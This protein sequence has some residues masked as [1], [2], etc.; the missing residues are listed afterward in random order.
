MRIPAAV[1]RR[2]IVLLAAFVVCG[3]VL[4]SVFLR[5]P[6]AIGMGRYEAVAQ[7]KEGAGLYQGAEVTYRGVPVGKVRSLALQNGH[8]TA[9]MSLRED[10]AIPSDV[11]AAIR[12]RSAVGEQYIALMEPET[13]TAA[14]RLTAGGVVPLSRTSQ[15]VEIGPLLDN[16]YALAKSLNA[17]DVNSTVTELGKA[18]DGRA[19]DLQ[20]IIDRGTSFT[21]QVS[22]NLKPTTRLLDDAE[23][24]LTRVNDEQEHIEGLTRSLRKVTEELRKGDS[25]LRQLMD[26]GPGFSEEV[27]RLLDDLDRRL[28]SVVT[29]LNIVLKVLVAYDSHLDGTL[30]VYPRSQATVQSV[31]LGGGDPN[32]IRLTLSNIND[33]AE[34]MK[35]FEP[36]S[37]WLSPFEDAPTTLPP[38]VYCKESHDDPRGVRGM[39]NIPCP[40]AP[41]VRTGDATVCLERNRPPKEK[42]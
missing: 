20:T 29:P 18:L 10:V 28:P 34:C 8:V 4:G 41:A 22:A 33:P 16:T 3:A 7:F 39:R 40:L 21:G 23:P 36:V 1:V 13:A 12:S 14:G 31:A 19:T 25:D 15:P 2:L 42:Q 30:A 26:D 17:D 6:E 24:L 32:K 35:G 37:Q 11:A 38:L 9:T 5:V 27:V